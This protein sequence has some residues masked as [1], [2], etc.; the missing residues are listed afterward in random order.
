GRG[1]PASRRRRIR[2]LCPTQVISLSTLR[3]VLLFLECGSEAAA[4]RVSVFRAMR[5]LRER[6]VICAGRTGA[7]ERAGRAPNFEGRQEWEERKRRERDE[8]GVISQP[9]RTSQDRNRQ[10][11]NPSTRFQTNFKDQSPNHRYPAT[12]TIG[13]PVLD[14]GHW[15]IGSCFGIWSLRFE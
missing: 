13:S 4:L 10:F 5:R 2:V 9:A 1:R 14:V 3:A 11:Q 12:L 7:A 8:G 15:A 6:M